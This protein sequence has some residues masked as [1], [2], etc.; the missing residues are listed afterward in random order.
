MARLIESLTL[1]DIATLTALDRYRYLDSAQ[2][3]SLYFSGRRRCE[4]RLRWLTNRGLVVRWVAIKPRGWRQRNSVYVLAPLGARALASWTGQD[5]RPILA[6]SKHARTHRAHVVHDLEANGFFVGLAEASRRLAHE[7][8][9]AWIG[10][11]TCRRTY[12]GRG[13]N[14]TP[15]GWGRYIIGDRQVIFFLEW[16][17]ATESPARLRAKAAAY[18][19]HFHHRR[20]AEANNVLF[21][22]P[23]RARELSVA[24][25]I[26]DVLPG[27]DRPCCRFFTT[28]VDLLHSAGSIGAVWTDVGK[29][30]GPRLR[31]SELHPLPHTAFEVRDCISKERWWEVRMGAGEA[32]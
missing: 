10:E 7:G 28:T 8:L 32:V 11:D 16:D 5:P 24:Q 21:V 31:L 26:R 3:E 18:V 23:R 27:D 22:T 13:E 30:A 25:A 19:R 12:R 6:R 20:Q 9:H 4:A 29:D 1:R 15:D 17:R 14:L 2:I